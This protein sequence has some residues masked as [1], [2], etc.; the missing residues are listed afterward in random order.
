MKV[1]LPAFGRPSR[2]TSANT[3]ISIF[4]SRWSPGLPGVVWR[5]AR[6]VLDLKRVLPRP[7]QPPWA[8]ISFWPGVTRSP[9]TSWVEAS[10]TVVPTGTRRNRSSPFLPVQSVLP[11]L[12]PRWASW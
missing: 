2:P 1:L 10:I 8:T 9:I 3:F 7:C 4:R 11:P 6:L 5:G 12:E